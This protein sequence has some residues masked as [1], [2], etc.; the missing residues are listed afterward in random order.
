MY[1]FKS[2]KIIDSGSP[3]CQEISNTSELRYNGGEEKIKIV[4]L[5]DIFFI[6]PDPLHGSYGFTNRIFNRS[7]FNFFNLI[8]IN[9]FKF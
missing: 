5:L 1:P 2:I 4:F 9:Y 8:T 3:Y 6:L 7:F